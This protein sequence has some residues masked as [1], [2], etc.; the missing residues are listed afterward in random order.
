MA[1]LFELMVAEMEEGRTG[2]AGSGRELNSALGPLAACVAATAA[3]RRLADTSA[4]FLALWEPLCGT[5]ALPDA[6][7]GSSLVD[8]ASLPV[9]P[10]LLA[11]PAALLIHFLTGVLADQPL[12]RQLAHTQQLLNLRFAQAALHLAQ[13]LAGGDASSL[14]APAR[15]DAGAEAEDEGAACPEEL[16]VWRW[17]CHR[18]L[19]EEAA[20]ERPEWPWPRLRAALGRL[21]QPFLAFALHLHSALSPAAFGLDGTGRKLLYTGTSGADQ[22]LALLRQ[23]MEPP[24]A[25]ASFVLWSEAQPARC[26]DSWWAEVLTS[27][28]LPTLKDLLCEV[29]L[30]APPRLLQLPPAYDA[31]FQRFLHSLCPKCRTKPKYVH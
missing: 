11:D 9:L 7:T 23:R 18:M 12:P 6:A 3:T 28:S 27:R 29:Q 2:R 10:L 17:A 21:L 16:A 24:S 25:S 1:K 19:G 22:S 5:D 31:L 4:T 20:A 30:W 26:L 14:L 8:P 13:E 15:G